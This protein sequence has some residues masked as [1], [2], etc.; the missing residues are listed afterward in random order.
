MCVLSRCTWSV[1]ILSVARRIPFDDPDTLNLV[2][3]GYVGAQLFIL[4][5]YYYISS[6]VCSA[7]CFSSAT[8]SSSDQ[9]KERPDCAQVWSVF[10]TFRR[11]T[12]S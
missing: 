9:E 4:L 12:Y 8:H 10:E 1:L 5:V 6:Q 7:P 3:A 2:R 11:G